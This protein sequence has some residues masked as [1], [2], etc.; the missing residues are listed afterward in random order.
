M[1]TVRRAIR[2]VLRSSVRSG[3]LVAVL[4]VSIGLALTMITVNEAFGQRLDEIKGE[5]GNSVTVRPAG[6]FGGGAF[7]GIR[8]FGGPEGESTDTETVTLTEDDVSDLSSIE[9]VATISMR[10]TNPY[11]GDGLESAVEPPAGIGGQAPT[12]PDGQVIEFSVPILAT[13]T[14]DTERLSS[15]GVEDADITS[16][17]MFTADDEDAKVAIVGESIA[18]KNG[19]SVGD[20]F[21]M[22]GTTME[23][24]GI[25]TTGTQFGD[26][27]VF[28]PLGTAQTLFDREGAIDEATVTATSADRVE[29]V[30]SDV[31]AALGEDVAD[32]TSDQSA[33]EG[34][35]APVSDAKDSSQM[36]MIVALVAS[37]AIILFSVVLVMRQR[38]KEIGIFKAI[39]ASN[40]HVAAQFGI[41]TSIVAVA[42]ALIGAVATFPLAQR[43][44]DGLVSD[45]ATPTFAG[46][47]GGPP[48]ANGDTFVVEAP[49]GIAGAADNVLGSVD[50]AVSLEVFLYAIGIAIGLALVAAIA[51]PFYVGRVKPAEVLRYE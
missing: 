22:D 3:L 2:A 20:T 29:Q 33:F 18:E 21:D 50:V 16:G 30:A 34:I 11:T 9:N 26:N 42:A 5:I 31:R 32:V 48:G 28:L 13:G 12:G 39:G 1:N 14:S 23:V 27:G 25:F 40:W 38:V 36:G 46:P 47:G 15:F 8:V 45:P 6:S 43:V 17:R 51:P 49:G 35:S 19:L 10:I 44:A 4:A 41:E 37:A 24:V 7:A